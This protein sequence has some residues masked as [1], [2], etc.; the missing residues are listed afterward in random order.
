MWAVCRPVSV[1]INMQ[2]TV[3]VA[4]NYI[5]LK[6]E[7]AKLKILLYSVENMSPKASV[8][9]LDP[10]VVNPFSSR[11]GGGVNSKHGF[12]VFLIGLIFFS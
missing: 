10:R 1:L 2:K 8:L 3:V 5:F 11:F 6:K 7:F 4:L 12:S 9:K